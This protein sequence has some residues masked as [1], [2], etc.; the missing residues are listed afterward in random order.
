[1][2]IYIPVVLMRLIFVVAQRLAVPV[3]PATFRL[4]KT[5][6][7]VGAW[8]CICRTETALTYGPTNTLPD[9][10]GFRPMYLS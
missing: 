1:V 7:A 4:M 3:S 6:G 2:R 8:Q 9:S 10:A 5:A